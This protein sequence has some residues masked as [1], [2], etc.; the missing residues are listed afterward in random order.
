MGVSHNN[1]A[2][3][4]SYWLFQGKYPKMIYHILVQIQ[5]VK[6]FLSEVIEISMFMLF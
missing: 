3:R 2:K 4:S 1:A 5:Y 6:L